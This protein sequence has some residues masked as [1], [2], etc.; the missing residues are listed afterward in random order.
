MKRK[1]SIF[2]ILTMLCFSIFPGCSS[3]EIK[4]ADDTQNKKIKLTVLNGMVEVADFFDDY[5]KKYNQ[6]NKD[7]IVVQTEYEKEST[8]S[9]DVKFASDNSPDI[10]IGVV[11][12]QNMIDKGN[13]VDLTNEAFWNKLNPSDKEYSTDVKSGK[14]YNV[15]LC[16]TAAGLFYNK[17]IFSELGLKPADTWEKFVDNLKVIKEKKPGI[18]PFYIGGRDSWMLEHMANFIQG[19]VIKQTLSYEEQQKAMLSLNLD[20]LKWNSAPDGT[21]ATYAKNLMELQKLGLINED[22]VKASYGNQIEA[23]AEGK[24]AVIS[25]GI[26]A[27]DLIAQKNNQV[28][29]IGFC[30]YPSILKGEK[31]VVGTGTDVTVYISSKSKYKDACMTPEAIDK[32]LAELE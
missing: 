1:I 7:G 27:A 30:Q 19:G 20:K 32:K 23:F 8:K 9:L 16:Q 3:N 26:W 12:N 14:A 13:F 31:P 6:E 11:V 5:F 29:N 4:K 24:A 25:Q 17:A 18:I 21:L 15:G 28:N 2:M 10:I 22:A